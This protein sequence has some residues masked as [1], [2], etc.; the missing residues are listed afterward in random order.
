MSKKHAFLLLPLLS[1][2]SLA[3][4]ELEKLDRGIASETEP[5]QQEKIASEDPQPEVVSEKPQE[6]EVA[7][8]KPEQKEV[9]SEKPQ[10]KEV[11]LSEEDKKKKEEEEEKKLAEEKAKEEARKKAEEDKKIAEEK[12]KEEAKKKEEEEKKIAEAKKKEEE[13]EKKKKHKEDELC[14]HPEHQAMNKQM[15]LLVTQQQSITSHLNQMQQMMYMQKMELEWKIL[16]APFN[17]ISNF[18]QQDLQMPYPSY[19]NPY[20]QF[21]QPPIQSLPSSYMPGQYYPQASQGLFGDANPYSQTYPQY[22]YPGGEIGVGGGF[23][24]G[25]GMG[26]L[27]MGPQQDPRNQIR[28]YQAGNFGV[29]TLGFNLGGQSQGLVPTQPMQP[30][31]P[32]TQQYSFMM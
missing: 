7:S 19:Y 5:V 24:G 22:S 20:Q 3:P 25:M 14:E 27:Y 18:R 10:E 6:K 32:Q 2:L 12:E 1:I 23:L 8:E 21:Q 29:D 17:S 13:E 11:I 16:T 31:Q 30:M 9:V 26:G 28:P 15:Q 4:H